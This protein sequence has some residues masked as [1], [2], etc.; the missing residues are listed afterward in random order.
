MFT[1]LVYCTCISAVHVVSRQQFHEKG[2]ILFQLDEVVDR[3]SGFLLICRNS[4]S[5]IC[6]INGSGD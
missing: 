2:Y 3:Y 5:K 6:W 4:F 1:V